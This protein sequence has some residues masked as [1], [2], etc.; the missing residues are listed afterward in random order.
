[1]RARALVIALLLA[2]CRAPPPPVSF[3]GAVADRGVWH[4]GVWIPAIWLRLGIPFDG[5]K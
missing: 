5:E 1:M 2:G 3:G 4:D